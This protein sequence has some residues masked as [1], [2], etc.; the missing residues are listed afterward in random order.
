MRDWVIRS[1]DDCWKDPIILRKE[2][3]DTMFTL[4]TKLMK[5]YK[6]HGLVFEQKSL[7]KKF[8]S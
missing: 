3:N 2:K 6:M 8:K 7:T 4:R 1:F 5:F